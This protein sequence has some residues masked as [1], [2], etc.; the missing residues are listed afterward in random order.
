MKCIRKLSLLILC[1]ICSI[2]CYSQKNNLNKHIISKQDT[3]D[4]H[5]LEKLKLLINEVDIYINSITSKSKLSA[6]SIVLSC[7]KYNFDIPFLLAAGQIESCFGTSGKAKRT[8]SIFN[9]S[10]HNKRSPYHAYDDPNKSIEHY[11][12]IIKNNFIRNRTVN[13]ILKPGHF[14]NAQ[15]KRYAKNASYE[16]KLKNTRKKII[17]QTNIIYLQD[18]LKNLKETQPKIL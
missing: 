13:H 3:I 15:G 4:S 10:I 1:I 12:I 9:M 2:S 8:N 17:K 16:L 6:D 7:L 18:I 11:I 14:K 5:Y